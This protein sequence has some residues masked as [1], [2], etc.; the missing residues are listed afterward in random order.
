VNHEQGVLEDSETQKAISDHGV[1]V[2]RHQTHKNRMD[3]EIGVAS[4]ASEMRDRRLL[5]PTSTTQDQQKTYTLRQHFKNWDS[6]PKKIRS[7]NM[8]SA[9]PDDLAMAIWMGVLEARALFKRAERQGRG[10]EKK[11]PA[12]I[13]RRWQK[14]RY[15][16]DEKARRG[17]VRRDVYANVDLA[18]L[19]AG[20]PDAD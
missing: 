3:R 20:T 8:R 14:K 18:Q 11:I 10:Q 12:A 7:K 2:V 17:N 13:A 16:Q 15:G 19:V 9:N 4:V 1:T 5:F 6:A